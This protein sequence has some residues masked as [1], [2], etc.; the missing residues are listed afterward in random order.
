[1]LVGSMSAGFWDRF[2]AFL[3]EREGRISLLVT[4][5]AV[6]IVVGVYI[7]GK[8]RSKLR[9]TDSGSNDLMT[10][11]RELHSRGDLSDEEYRTIKAS[12]TARLQREIK[13]T[14]KTG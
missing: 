6:L 11:F 14:D 1:M 8:M 9:E 5:M 2:V 4:A 10:N 12:L 13:G 7:I 3:D